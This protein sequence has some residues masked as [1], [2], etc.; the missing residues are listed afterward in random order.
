MA[1]LEQQPASRSQMGRCPGNDDT[2]VGQ[3]VR[4]GHQRR[5][6]LETQVAALQ[7]RISRRHIGRIG[8]NHVE[9]LCVQGVEPVASHESNAH[10]CCDSILPGNVQCRCGNV[11]C[12]NA[13][14]RPLMSNGDGNATAAGAQIEH[15]MRRIPGQLLKCCINQR[16]G[17]RAW[18]Q[19]IRRD[20]KIEAVEFTPANQIG[21]RFAGTTALDKVAKN[22]RGGWIG[23]L[24]SVR[25]EPGTGHT[26]RM[27]E[28]YLRFP[29]RLDGVGEISCPI[30]E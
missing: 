9:A 10:S 14:G 4:P 27:S 21:D 15:F 13:C 18:N 16:F 28:Q 30:V 8:N 6:R 24:V 19:Y 5:F 17:I 12:G 11:H 22:V 1:V 20:A 3:P 2:D 29:S 23:W 26:Q 7:M 25:R